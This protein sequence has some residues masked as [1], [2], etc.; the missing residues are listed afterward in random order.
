MYRVLFFCNESYSLFPGGE[1]GPRFGGAEL[2]LYTIADEISKNESFEVTW[3]FTDSKK[4][5]VSSLSHPR[6]N[7]LERKPPFGRN[8][9]ILSRYFNRKR[10]IRKKTLLEPYRSYSPDVIISTMG[11]LAEDLKVE[12]GLTG[13]K[14]VFRVASDADVNGVRVAFSKRPEQILRDIASFDSVVV[15]TDEQKTNLRKVRKGPIVKIAKFTKMSTDAPSTP[16]PKSILW[17]ASCQEIKQPQLFLSLAKNFPSEHFVMIM[18]PIDKKLGQAVSAEAAG[19]P[20]LELIYE[21]VPRE[22]V[23]EYFASAKLFV[24]TSSVEGFP[25][26]FLEACSVGIPILSYAFNPDDM[27][28]VHGIGLCANDSWSGLVEQ[29]TVLLSDKSL[30]EEKG[31]NARVYFEQNHNL[32]KIVQ[33][34]TSLIASVVDDDNRPE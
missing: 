14:T 15:A 26:T 18:P 27:I 2:Q 20:N 8:V 31:R 13:A 28:N 34:W 6:M 9:P 30:L 32:E 10:F 17:V 22:K 16:N 4:Y 25:N 21:Q 29:C 1:E 3:L 7:I 19:I 12:A 11:Y 23:A 5:N 33:D 24:N